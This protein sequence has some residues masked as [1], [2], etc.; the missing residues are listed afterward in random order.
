MGITC[1]SSVSDN[2][3][4]IVSLGSVSV[5]TLEH[6]V[7]H[8]VEAATG[9]CYAPYVFYRHDLLLHLWAGREGRGISLYTPTFVS[10]AMTSRY[11]CC[12]HDRGGDVIGMCNSACTLLLRNQYIIGYQSSIYASESRCF[13]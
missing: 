5:L 13:L 8:L 6:L 7:H 2:N 11:T 3:T 12:Y 9:V 10:S 4:Y 1:R